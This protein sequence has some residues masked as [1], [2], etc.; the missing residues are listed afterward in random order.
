MTVRRFLLLGFVVLALVV[1]TVGLAAGCGGTPAN[2]TSSTAVAADDT[3]SSSLAATTLNSGPATTATAT[4][5]TTSAGAATTITDATTTTAASTTT[6][7][8]ATTTTG[9]I[10]LTVTGPSGSKKFTMAQLKA[11]GSASGYGGWKNRVGNITAPM[12]WKGVSLSA[13]MD[14]VGGGSSV[15]V[16]ASDGYQQSFSSGELSGGVTMYDPA[17]GDPVTS[18]NGKLRVIVAYSQG[19]SAI[20]SGEGPLRIAFISPEKDQVTDGS[21][22]AKP[23]VSIKVN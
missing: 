6:T 11:L 10:V 12:S 16:T 9:P 4:S 14:Q 23:V 20:G 17:T 18:I 5:Q 22:R 2:S 13:L 15:Q 8:K 19:G 1:A 7:A 21:N 3:T